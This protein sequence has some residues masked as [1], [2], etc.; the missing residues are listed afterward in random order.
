MQAGW[1]CVQC[2]GVCR[3][4]QQQQRK[5]DHVYPPSGVVDCRGGGLDQL[6][7]IGFYRLHRTTM[8]R[9]VR[10]RDPSYRVLAGRAG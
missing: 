6:R 9:G 2:Q 1:E 5:G 3:S 7:T 10:L 8:Q 4:Q